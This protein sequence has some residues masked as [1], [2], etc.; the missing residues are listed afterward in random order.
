MADHLEHLPKTE[1]VSCFYE[2]QE[3]TCVIQLYLQ[4]TKLK[5]LGREK[6]LTHL[7]NET[8]GNKLLLLTLLTYF[9]NAIEEVELYPDLVGQADDPHFFNSVNLILDEL[10]GKI[11]LCDVGLSTHEDTLARHGENFYQSENVARYIREMKFFH[12]LLEEML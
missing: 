11:I 7:K 5:K 10:T 2:E 6:I 12:Q 4:G 9:F 3:Q 1:I 8:L